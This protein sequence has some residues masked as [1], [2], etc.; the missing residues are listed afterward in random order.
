MP[1]NYLAKYLSEND[2]NKISEV[3]SGI[4]EHTS[5]EIRLCI[6]VRRGIILEGKFT[7]R[8]LALDEF[9]KAGMQNT[10]NKTGVLIFILFSER[11]FEIIADEGINSKISE[12][13]WEEI[14][15]E[16]SGEFKNENYLEGLTKAIN[17]I[18]NVLKTEFPPS[19][20]NPDELSNEVIVK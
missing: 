16:I 12:S 14:K 1:R 11:K 17:D 9:L 3:I 4:E 2:L 7:P 8:E 6:K 20:D 18:G 13:H 5:G 15:N 10:K 19:R